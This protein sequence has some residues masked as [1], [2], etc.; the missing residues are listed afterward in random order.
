M[1]IPVSSSI[2]PILANTFL[3]EG[4]ELSLDAI[5]PSVDLT[6]SFIP[7]TSKMEFYIY[8]YSKTLLYENLNYSINGSHISFP[9]GTST[10][11]STSSYNRV[12]LSPIDDVYNQGF[13]NGD[14]F[15]LYNFVD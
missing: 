15:A 13:S 9:P 5:V 8:D 2:T 10:S 4:F 3:Q 12:E 14:Y 7:D 1:A 6:G 11:T